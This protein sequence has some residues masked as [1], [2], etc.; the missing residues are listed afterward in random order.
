MQSMALFLPLSDR[1][2]R[3]LWFTESLSELIDDALSQFDPG[4]V[5]GHGYGGDE[6][7]IWITLPSSP[8]AIEA[9]QDLA[10]KHCPQG[11]RVYV[12]HENDDDEDD[13][14]SFEKPLFDDGEQAAEEPLPLAADQLAYRAF[15]ISPRSHRPSFGEKDRYVFK[16]IAIHPG[17]DVTTVRLWADEECGISA[18]QFV[19]SLDRLQSSGY[20]IRFKGAFAVP[21]DIIKQLPH[22]ARGNVSSIRHDAWDAVFK[23]IF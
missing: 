13:V 21:E 16:S 12:S 5:G 23:A 17:C 8:T 2:D 4:G 7:E 20:I 3:D 15:R 6:I 18:A 1:N 9:V 22:T 11:T 19:E 10:R 14:E